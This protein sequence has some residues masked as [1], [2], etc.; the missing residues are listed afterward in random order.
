MN[1]LRV[2][3]Q[4]AGKGLIGVVRLD[5]QHTVINSVGTHKINDSGWYVCTGKNGGWHDGPFS[6]REAIQMAARW[7]LPQKKLK[8]YINDVFVGYV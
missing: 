4:R 7:A 2:L 5:T 8:M 1:R 6:K 3:K